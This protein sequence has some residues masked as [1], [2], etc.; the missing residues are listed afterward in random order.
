VVKAD[1]R[2]L[3]TKGDMSQDIPVQ[4]GDIIFV[5]R[6][7]TRVEFGSVLSAVATLRWILW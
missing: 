1:L 6:R 5:P 3:L 7:G 4:K 2:K